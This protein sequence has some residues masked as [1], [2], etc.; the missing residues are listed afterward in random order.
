MRAWALT[1][2]LAAGLAGCAA[3]TPVNPRPRDVRIDGVDPCSLLTPAQRTQLG[4]NQPPQ[5]LPGDTKGDRAICSWRG[6]KPRA[7]AAS[8]AVHTAGGI[9]IFDT[10]SNT[11]SSRMT[12]RDFPAVLI[13]LGGRPEFCTVAI[14][15][16]PGEALGVQFADYGLKPP[17]PQDRLCSDA[18]HVSDLVI[19]NLLTQR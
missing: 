17:I 12:V 10:T 7:V 8:L 15:I 4:L 3:P 13:K 5:F 16:S 14:D 11:T 18:Q 2:V 6:D 19:D 9:E 1:M